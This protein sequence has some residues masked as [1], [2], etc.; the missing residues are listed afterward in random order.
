MGATRG[1]WLGLRRGQ[2]QGDTHR[3]G[4]GP[5]PWLPSGHGCPDSAP[6]HS[7]SHISFQVSADS[8]TT[9][10]A[11]QTRNPSHSSLTAPNPTN[12]GS[13]TLTN[14]ALSPN[15]QQPLSGPCLAPIFPWPQPPAPP[16]DQGLTTLAE[17]SGTTSHPRRKMRPTPLGTSGAPRLLPAS[18][19]G[20]HPH[21]ITAQASVPACPPLAASRLSW[22][23]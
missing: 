8:P 10:L 22:P 18:A 3:Q 12:C 4:P 1:W 21:P 9:Q 7:G 5:E 20:R 15:T 14:P 19:S 2:E 23:R 16:C 11:V 13:E 6:L 17:L